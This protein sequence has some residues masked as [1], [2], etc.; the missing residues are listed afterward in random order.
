MAL[1]TLGMAVVGA[2]QSHRQA[3]A[4]NASANASAH[5]SQ[6]QSIQQAHASELTREAQA[7]ALISQTHSQNWQT[8][9]L[10]NQKT[11]LKMQSQANSLSSQ[12]IYNKGTA[13]MFVMGMVQGREFNSMRDKSNED[14]QFTKMWNANSDLI[15]QASIEADKTNILEAGVESLRAGAKADYINRLNSEAN[16]QKNSLTTSRQL[17]AAQRSF[18]SSVNKTWMTVGQTAIGLNKAYG[19]SGES[20]FSL[21]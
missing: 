10:N 5:Q 16:L 11:V 21:F 13:S 8:Q 2:Y 17:G 15:S 18:D 4:A 7:D 20:G 19:S 1:F 12:D 3:K 6:L 9:K 14:L